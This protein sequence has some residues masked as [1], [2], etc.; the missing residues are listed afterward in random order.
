MNR[1]VGVITAVVI[2]FAI[3]LLAGFAPSGQ[4]V[5]QLRTRLLSYGPWAVGISAGLMIT[6][7]VLAPLP[8]NVVS[9]TNGLVFGPFWGGLLSWISM[10]IGASISFMLSRTFGKPLALKFAGKSMSHAERFFRKYG[11][12]AMFLS[13]IVPFVPFDAISYAA[14]LV[15]VPYSTFLC[16]TAVGTIPSI[17]IYSYLGKVAGAAYW[18]I[19][20]GALGISLIGIVGALIATRKPRNV[21]FRPARIYDNV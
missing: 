5:E 16:A 4:G 21:P 12:P 9:I 6:Q 17:I 7:A 1:S 2:V 18:W 15:G 13:R 3:V 14:G 10:L 20:I 8:G 19:L 11:K